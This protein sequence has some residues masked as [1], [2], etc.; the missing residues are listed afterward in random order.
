MNPN[1]R[2][3]AEASDAGDA[4][5]PALSSFDGIPYTAK[6]SC[7]AKGLT[8]AVGSPAFEHLVAQHDAFAIERLRAAG[9]V[10]IGLTN[11]A[12]GER[13]HAARR[14]RPRRKPLQRRLTHQRLP[15]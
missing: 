11:T 10:L 15:R 13:R 2:A 14:L 3:D 9:A 5:G 8:A 12:D 4:R 1:A 6:D 7:L